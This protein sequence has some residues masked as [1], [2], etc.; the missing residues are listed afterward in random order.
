MLSKLIASFVALASLTGVAMA[1]QCQDDV[2]KI[3]AALAG[4]EL[5]ADV[6]AQLQDMRGQAAQLCAAGNTAEG[7]AVAAEALSLLEIK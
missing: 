1:D 6:R 7:I 3:D 4:G 2:A 5:D